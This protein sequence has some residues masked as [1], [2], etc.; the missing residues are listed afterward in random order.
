[1]ETNTIT[2]KE[3]GETF[4]CADCM[5]TFPILTDGATGYAVLNE[6]TEG[7]RICYSCADKRQ[8][9]ALKDRSIPF[10]G[11]LSADEKTVTSWTGGKLMAVLYSVPC[12]LTRRSNW[13]DARSFRSVRAKDIHGG[14]WIGRGS[15]GVAIKMRAVKSR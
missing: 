3:S 10:V 14:E 5:K 15:S 9:E 13:H 6:G 8:V 12:A 1:M 7:I 11:Y 4:T 2:R